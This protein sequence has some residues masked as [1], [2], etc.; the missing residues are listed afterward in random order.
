MTLSVCKLNSFN[1]P[2]KTIRSRLSPLR[3]GRGVSPVHQELST[4]N[5]KLKAQNSK[6]KTQNSMKAIND[7]GLREKEIVR[8]TLVGSVVNALLVVLKFCAGVMASS[9]AM[10][11]D[12]VHSLSDF[13]TDFVVIVMLRVSSK[14]GDDNHDYGHG[15]FETLATTIIGLLLAVVGVGIL[16]SGCVKIWNFISGETVASPGW[17]AFYAAVV[18]VLMKEGIYQYTMIKGRHLNSDAMVANA[19]HHRSDALSSVGTA[20]GI[21]AACWFGEGWAILD[22]LAAVVVSLFIFKIA[23]KLIK[24]SVGQLLERSLP[25][26]TEDEIE[27]IVHSIEGVSGMHHLRTRQIGVNYVISMH[28]RM[29]G[30]ITLNTAHD[31]ATIIERLLKEKFGEQTIISIHVEPLK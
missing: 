8:I 28:I 19:W 6:P 31:K 16:W 11:A 12:A 4:Q 3:G 2:N 17:L 23:V 7:N 10:I 13:M 29:N 30:D 9:S 18:S 25:K 26:E 22:P 5:S 14:P 15:K 24:N 1:F 21:G 20:A 27:T